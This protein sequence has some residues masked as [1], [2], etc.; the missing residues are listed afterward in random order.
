MND[1]KFNLGAGGLGRPLAGEDHISGFVSILQDAHLPAGFSTSQRIKKI[2]SL[3][4]VV[5]LGIG[6]NSAHWQNI[7]LY[8]AIQTCY[9]IN[10]KAVLYIGIFNADASV[11]EAVI[12]LQN[13][14]EG[15]IRQIGVINNEQNL[16]AAYLNALQS[17]CDTL[18]AE[19]KPVSLVTNFQLD[20]TDVL[21]DLPNLRELQNKNVSVVIGA[22]GGLLNVTQNNQYASILGVTIGALSKAKVNENIGWVGRFDISKNDTGRFDVPALTNGV[23]IKDLPAA[24]LEDLNVKGYIFL[25]K[26]IGT[27]GTYFNDSA[28][29]IIETSDYAYIENV[30]T[31]DKAVR[32]TRTYLLPS[33][34]A[35]L[36]VNR[37]GTLT[38]DTIL[39]FKNDTSRALEEMQRNVE[40]SAFEVTINPNQNVLSTSKLAITIKI[41][42]VGVARNIE[43]NIGFAVK[44]G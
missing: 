22:D 1:I 10:K 27:A 3:E 11:P 43:V 14:S 18:E 12:S 40:I 25:L 29:A 33:L 6:P 30:R 7:N 37:D 8:Y 41:V 39:T 28:T 34:N 19:H 23:L 36:Y 24:A 4:E 13:Y 31:I 35:P 44:V 17:A 2:Y 42:P 15:K 26:H 38:E 32:N 20:N 9:E 16:T 5:N 21:A